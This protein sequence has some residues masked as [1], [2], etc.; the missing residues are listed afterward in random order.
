MIDIDECDAIPYLCLGGKC[1]NT[2]GSFTCECPPGQA[3]NPNTN[4][5]DDRD[6]CLDENICENGVCRNTIGGYYCLCNQGF[7]QSQDKT[8]CIGKCCVTYSICNVHRI[9]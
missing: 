4:K 5:C 7:I 1:S 8:Y 9:D 2:I 6:E 3:R